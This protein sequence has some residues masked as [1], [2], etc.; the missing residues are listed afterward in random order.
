[1]VEQVGPAD[2]L[3]VFIS[4]S[5]DDIEIADWLDVTLEQNGFAPTLDREG[6][7]GAKTGS[8]ASAR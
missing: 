7:S 1:M 3:F 5:R 6:I 8:S 2:R 4:Y